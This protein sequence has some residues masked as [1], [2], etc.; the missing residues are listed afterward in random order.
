MDSHLH[1]LDLIM[2]LV[3]CHTDLSS[4]PLQLYSIGCSAEDPKHLTMPRVIPW[5]VLHCLVP[6]LLKHL[7]EGNSLA[8]LQP[9]ISDQKLGRV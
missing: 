3:G 4:T 7:G 9:Y 5:E 6:I 1:L 8:S 2:L